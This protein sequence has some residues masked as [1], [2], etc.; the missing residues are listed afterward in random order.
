MRKERLTS[1]DT[2]NYYEL[3]LTETFGLGIKT[4]S[5]SWIGL[6]SEA[7]SL[8]T[9]SFGFRPNPQFKY[10]NPKSFVGP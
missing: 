9:F 6:K 10:P 1:K 4:E 2:S 3:D 8:N 7:E 5:F